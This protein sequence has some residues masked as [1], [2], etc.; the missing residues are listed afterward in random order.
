MKLLKRKWGSPL[1]ITITSPKALGRFSL[2]S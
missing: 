1:I 2:N